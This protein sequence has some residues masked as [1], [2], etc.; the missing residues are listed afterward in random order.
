MRAPRLSA[1]PVPA[2]IL[3]LLLCWASPAAAVSQAGAIVDTFHP[4]A[5]GAAMADAFG[6][7]ATGP[8]ALRWNPA[9]V[10]QEQRASVGA[11]YNQL[12]PDFA[13]DVYI[14]HVGA[15]ANFGA[16]GVGAYFARLDEGEFRSAGDPE[17]ANSNNTQTSMRFGAGVDFLDL[18]DVDTGDLDLG[19]ALGVD[20]K[21]L[22]VNLAGTSVTQ[23]PGSGGDGAEADA[24]TTDAGLLARVGHALGPAAADGTGRSRFA[25][26]ASLVFDGVNDA[27]LGFDAQSDPIHQSVRYGLGFEAELIPHPVFGSVV[28]LLVTWERLDSLVDQDDTSIDGLGVEVGLAKMVYL[29][30]GTTEDTEGQITAGTWGAG[31]RPFPRSW[32]GGLQLDYASF[33]EARGLSRVHLFTVSGDFDLF[34]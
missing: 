21:R 8:F 14:A 15:T 23:D 12:V 2:T 16:F 11:T 1:G 5:R 22:A 6:P 17:G 9:G 18:F 13:N 31:L 3:I 30:A 4:G 27:E 26:R 32:V 20:I 7:V 29:R 19:L 25:F 10:A 24:W 34:H 28:D 33:P